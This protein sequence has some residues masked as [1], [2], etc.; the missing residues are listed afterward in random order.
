MDRKFLI[1]GDL[2]GA[3]FL[4]SIANSAVLLSSRKPTT[5]QWGNA[6]Q[7]I[8][9]SA[10]FLNGELGTKNYDDQHEI[11]SFAIKQALSEFSPSKNYKIK[12]YPQFEKIEDIK[13]LISS[14]SVVIL[15]IN[16]D[17]WVS[18]SDLSISKKSL[19]TVCSDLG[20]RVNNYQ[21]NLCDNYG[22]YYNKVYTLNSD[23][24]IHKTSVVQI[25]MLA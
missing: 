2:D 7:Y 1:Q 16:G 20:D 18:V 10:D 4:Y 6:L 13:N 12:S 15:N 19:F 25:K 24:N 17:H 22:R 14:S 23:F 21:E 8:P 5:K 9:F 3:C 11:Y